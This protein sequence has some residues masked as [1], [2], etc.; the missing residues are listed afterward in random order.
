MPGSVQSAEY[1]LQSKAQQPWGN[2]EGKKKNLGV[3]NKEMLSGKHR[4]LHQ[5]KST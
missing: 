1:T 2:N 4:F 3:R 5:K